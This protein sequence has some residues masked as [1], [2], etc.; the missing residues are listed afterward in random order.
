MQR[1]VIGS[2]RIA[3]QSWRNGISYHHHNALAQSAAANSAPL[4]HGQ[5]AA[6]QHKHIDR[7]GVA[8]AAAMYHQ[9]KATN[10]TASTYRRHLRAPAA[11]HQH[12]ARL[13]VA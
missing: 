2:A 3:H 1:N 9:P 5:S 10:V 12:R 4:R 8:S 11:H 6:Y 13:N 7:A